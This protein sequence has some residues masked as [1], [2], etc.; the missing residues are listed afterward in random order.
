MRKGTLVRFRAKD[1]GYVIDSTDIH[2]EG[3]II[4]GVRIIKEGKLDEDL[5]KV[6]TF[7]S[8]LPEAI[9]VIL[10]PK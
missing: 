9:R 1:A 4:P 3:I 8:R 5:W 10:G 7:N 2:Q 6:L